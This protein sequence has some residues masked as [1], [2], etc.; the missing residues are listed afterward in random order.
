MNPKV[1]L[2]LL[3]FTA[4]LLNAT[5]AFAIDRTTPPG[6]EP[7]YSDSPVKIS[8]FMW[9]DT[10]YQ[11][12]NNETEDNETL[13]T[14]EGRFNLHASVE[15]KIGEYIISAHAE[16]LAHVDESDSY[17]VDTDDVYMK[18]GTKFWDLQLGRF[19]PW[20]IYEK[21]QGLELYTAE[22]EGAAKGANIYEVDYAWGRFNEV[23]Q[24]AFHLFPLNKLG[25]ELSGLY[26]QERNENYL[27]ARLA[28]DYSISNFQIIAGGEYVN[29]EPDSEVSQK[30]ADKFGFG[31]RI[32]YNSRIFTMG[33][34][35]A[36]GDVD[37]TTTLGKPDTGASVVVQS[38]GGFIDIDFWKNSIGLGFNHTSI[39]SDNKDKLKHIQP[40][41]SYLYRLPAP[42]ASIKVVA[43]YA[44][45]DNDYRTDVDCKN[46]MYSIRVRTR[47]NF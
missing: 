11:Q 9:I 37:S 38:V 19:L 8:G 43:A 46:D 32:Q 36:R 6:V 24:F 17:K 20:K 30:T 3:L 12:K 40:Y 44:K 15:Q 4:V 14:M 1:N 22:D 16:F 13:Q 45:A 26:G 2:L 39:E 5:S 34:N 18:F 41:I 42:N 31:G 33:I 28:L 21:G 29:I 27:G 23:G 35:Y 47:Y 7:Q 25:L 10:S